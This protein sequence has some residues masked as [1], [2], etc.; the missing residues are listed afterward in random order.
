MDRAGFEPLIPLR[1]LSQNPLF[2]YRGRANW[3]KKSAMNAA[4]KETS[5]TTKLI[6]LNFYIYNFEI[7]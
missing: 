6:Q 5:K 7:T 4:D 3:N 2:L 1:Y